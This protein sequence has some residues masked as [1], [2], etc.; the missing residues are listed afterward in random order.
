[1]YDVLDSVS[2]VPG[3]ATVHATGFNMTCGFLAVPTPFTE[4]DGAWSTLGP[5][6]ESLVVESTR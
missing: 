5:S 3:N 6:N 1:L 4:S 2:P